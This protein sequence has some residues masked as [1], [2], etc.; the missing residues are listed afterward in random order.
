MELRVVTSL[1][2]FR[3]SLSPSFSLSPHIPPL[4]LCLSVS[5]ERYITRERPVY[6]RVFAGG[7]LKPN[8]ITLAGSEPA[9]NQLA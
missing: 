4:S 9:P 6:T 5:Y 7:Q 3:I 8:S 2:N 1:C